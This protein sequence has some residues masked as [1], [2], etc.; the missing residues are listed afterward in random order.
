MTKTIYLAGGCFWGTEHFMGLIPGVTATEVGYANSNTPDPSYQL[1]CT[2]TTDAAETVRVDYDPE[3]VTLRRILD[4]YF[5]TIDPTSVNRQGGD[6]GTQYRTGI[7]YTDPDD[8]PTVDAALVDLAARCSGPIAVE[9]GRLV[10]FYPAEKYHQGY[11]DAN[12]GGY[13]HINPALF[14]IARHG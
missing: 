7:Y 4:L 5:L 6:S 13:C 2:G 10:N 11:L 9:S 12:H 8:A 14:D 1:V 3:R